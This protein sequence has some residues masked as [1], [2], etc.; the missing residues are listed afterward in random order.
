VHAEGY[1]ERTKH[2]DIYYH[3]IKDRVKAGHISLEHVRTYNMAAD[4]LT[5]PLDRL[6]HQ[7]FLDQIGLRKPTIGSPAYNTPN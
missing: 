5:K 1:H 3:Y 6:S 2:V 7:R 4:G